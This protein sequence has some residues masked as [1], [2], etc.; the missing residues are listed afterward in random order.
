MKSTAGGGTASPQARSSSCYRRGRRQQAAAASGCMCRF[1]HSQLQ[2]CS[3]A[4]PAAARLPTA[5]LPAR[6]PKS[7]APLLLVLL[8]RVAGVG[9][10]M[11]SAK[12]DGK[13]SD[14]MGGLA[15]EYKGHGDVE[16]AQKQLEEALE[17]GRT[18]GAGGAG[19]GGAIQL[20][21]R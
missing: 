8:H 19:A 17:G 3:P 18:G 11:V 12:G 2:H 14:V 5:R 7:A 21:A 20:L 6:L 10:M 13:A 9:R 15:T 1:L 4:C 16:L